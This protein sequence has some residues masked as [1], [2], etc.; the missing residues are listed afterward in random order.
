MYQELTLSNGARIL[1]E[2]VAGAR[3]AALGFFVGAGS[4]HESA[5]ENGAAHFIEHMLFKGTAR[6]SAA[7]LARD[8]DAIGGQVNAYTTKE[9]TCF[10][11]RSLD[12]HLD[13]ALDILSDMLFHSRFAQK[14]VEM[15][16]SVILEEIGMY[17]DA[18]DDLVSERLA[19]AVAEAG[20]R[21]KVLCRTSGDKFVTHG[22]L[23][24]L[25]QELGLD[26]AGIFRAALEEVRKHG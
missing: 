13:Q 1:L 23:S 2:R 22:A 25:K 4:R 10:Y 17:E 6:R 14:D 18:P 9:H 16:R 8:M 21:A 15:E 7:Q 11:A 19:A 3:S 12:R 24:C 26:S 5:V 20:L